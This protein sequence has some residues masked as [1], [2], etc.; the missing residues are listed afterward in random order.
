MN[1]NPFLNA[2]MSSQQQ[3]QAPAPKRR[4]RG[5]LAGIWDR[6][7]RVIAPVVGAGLGALTGGLAAPAIAGG[8]MRGLDRP[9]KRGIGFDVGAGARGAVEGAMAGSVGKAA[10]GFG[11]RLL[12]RG[13]TEAAGQAGAAGSTPLDVGTGIGQ[14]TARSSASMTD[15]IRG[16]AERAGRGLRAVGRFAKENPEA[17][18]MG[19]QAASGVMGAQAER[20]MADERIALERQ[21]DEEERRRRET[22]ARLLLPLF[23]QMQGQQGRL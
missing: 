8:L 4:K 14:E 12:G 7:K 13:A 20:Q 5:G 16:G 15:Y 19:L 22:I 6:N 21:R 23:Q 3:Q 2:L 9:G 18:G 1:D 11:S 10:R 17:I